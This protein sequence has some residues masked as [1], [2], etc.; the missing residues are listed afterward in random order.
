VGTANIIASQADV[1]RLWGFIG[2]GGGSKNRMTKKQ[3][4][5]MPG[6]ADHLVPNQQE[7]RDGDCRPGLH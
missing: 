1:G 7:E 4:V 5:P 2:T 3:P 6:Q